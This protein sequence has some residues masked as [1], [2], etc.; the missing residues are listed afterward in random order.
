MLRGTIRVSSAFMLQVPI[1]K[2]AQSKIS[3]PHIGDL[4]GIYWD[5]RKENGSYDSISKLYVFTLANLP[6]AASID[7]IISVAIIIL[8][9]NN[10]IQ[11]M[12]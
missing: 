9:N 11:R 7:L 3:K 12:K 10:S 4:W 8:I 2:Q 6:L 5:N 1:V